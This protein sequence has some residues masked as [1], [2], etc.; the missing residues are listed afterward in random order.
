[1]TKY[2]KKYQ[3]KTYTLFIGACL[4]MLGKGHLLSQSGDPACFSVVRVFFQ[5]TAD[6]LSGT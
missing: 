3:K 1:M 6:F 2:Q 4:V 5:E